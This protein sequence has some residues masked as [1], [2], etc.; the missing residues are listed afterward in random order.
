MTVW[1][2]RA[3]TVVV[4]ELFPARARRTASHDHSLTTGPSLL[5]LTGTRQRKYFIEAASMVVK[6]QKDP[7]SLFASVNT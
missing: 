5:Q 1:L 2:W 6:V 3:S 7:Y 4:A